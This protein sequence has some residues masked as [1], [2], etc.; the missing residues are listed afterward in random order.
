MPWKDGLNYKR[1]DSMTVR[2]IKKLIMRA[3]VAVMLA[4][5]PL[6]AALSVTGDYAVAEA[7]TVKLASPS[8]SKK[9]GTYKNKVT[10]TIKNK[11]SKG[12]LYYTTDGKT[13]TTKSKI[14]KKA[15][16]FKKTTVLKVRCIS[17]SQ[18]SSVVT[19]KYVIKKADSQFTPM[20]ENEDTTYSQV[21]KYINALAY[22]NTSSLSEADQEICKKAV[23]ILQEVV[24]DSMSTEEKAKVI[25]DYIINQTVYDQE[26]YLK[27]TIP[28]DSYGVKGVLLKKKAVCQGYAE[29]YYML[30]YLLDI[31]CKIIVSTD[32][33]WNLVKLSDGKWYHVDC[34]WDDPVMAKGEQVL[35]YNYLFVD[36]TIMKQDHQ[37][38]AK[39]Y[40]VCDGT[41]YL[42]YAY[43]DG[44]LASINDFADAVRKAYAEGKH[45]LTV[46]YP[47]EG[48]PD[49]QIIYDIT[50]A[51]R[52]GYYP[53]EKLGKYTIFTVMW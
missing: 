33:A 9:A 36:D 45:E 17:G 27:G 16:T 29:T 53:P 35:R 43:G 32:H 38:I 12:K 20:D 11:A 48:L 44:K 41:K 28:Q 21:S 24:D 34:T 52:V 30:L 18:K 7:A 14:Y 40:P 5:T 13:P 2:G 23:A 22:Q 19:R 6:T 25:H 39:N 15:L 49:L 1:G 31:P 26:N 42:Y 4:V 10:V 8:V 3:T 46:L 47:E 51:N 50:G 37:W